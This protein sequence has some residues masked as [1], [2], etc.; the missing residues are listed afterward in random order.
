MGQIREGTA[1]SLR[2]RHIQVPKAGEWVSWSSGVTRHGST[3]FL[4]SRVPP[5][6]SGNSRAADEFHVPSKEKVLP[7]SGG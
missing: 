6:G 5:N 7:F 3:G 2:A 1:P 4:G